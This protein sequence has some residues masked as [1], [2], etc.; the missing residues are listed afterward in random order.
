MVSLN[1]VYDC[2]SVCVCMC[3]LVH[4][5]GQPWDD[6]PISL[7]PAMVAAFRLSCKAHHDETVPFNWAHISQ[8]LQDASTDCLVNIHM[9]G[10]FKQLLPS[11]L[12]WLLYLFPRITKPQ[13]IR[14]ADM[15][16]IVVDRECVQASQPAVFF[17]TSIDGAVHIAD[18]LYD[19]KRIH[20]NTGAKASRRFIMST[21]LRHYVNTLARAR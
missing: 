6:H 9:Y 5:R 10:S 7:E 15:G 19:I 1:C 20:D 16:P 2:Y 21:I 3:V 4:C 8:P 18:S 11:M 12:R 17:T 14:A 13:W